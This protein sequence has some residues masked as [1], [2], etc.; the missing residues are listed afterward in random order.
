MDVARLLDTFDPDVAL[1]R[2]W[3]PPASWYVE[4][5]VYEL[6]RTAVF[7][8]NWLYACRGAQ[9]AARK[10]FAAGAVAREPY[11]VVRDGNGTLRALSNVCR[12][13]AAEICSGDGDAERLVCPYHQWAYNLDGALLKAPELGGARDFER[14]QMGL[15]RYEVGELGPFAFLAFAKPR[16]TLDASFGA[17]H[18]RLAQTGYGELRYATSVTWEFACNWKVYVDNYLD[19]GYHIAH[20]HRGL[21]AGLKLDTYRS[22]LFER[23]SIQSVPGSGAA[24]I[25]DEAL[26]AWLYPNFMI[27]RYGPVMDTNLVLPFGHERTLVVMDYFFDASCTP[28]FIA[29]NLRESERIQREDIAIC[30][31]VQRGVASRSY[32]R[33][34]YSVTREAPMHAFHVLLA[35]DLRNAQVR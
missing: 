3:T 18:A 5:G 27:N 34:R 35:R 19:G 13:H 9:V 12:H 28:E 24:R 11:V 2:A 32:D 22:E 15:P 31:S 1:E 17:L 26:Y 20:L 33:G 6:E 7:G 16:A 30:E 8:A 4:R 21:A 29:A 23:Y 10:R 25:G 14:E